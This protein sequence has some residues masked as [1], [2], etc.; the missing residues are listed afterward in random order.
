[1]FFFCDLNIMV[2][3]EGDTMYE[4]GYL[5]APN[6]VSKK[7]THTKWIKSYSFGGDGAIQQ[8]R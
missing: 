2:L 4:V 3:N 6:H 8:K 5:Y 7:D 1:M